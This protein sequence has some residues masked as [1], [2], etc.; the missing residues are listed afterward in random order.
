MSSHLSPILRF[1]PFYRRLQKENDRQRAEIARLRADQADWTRFFPPGHFYSPLSSREEIAE[2]FTRGGFGP[3]FADID[4][5]EAEQLARLERFA[6]WYPE[7]PFSENPA[8]GARFHLDNPSYGHFDAI[9]LYGM[10]R[11]ARPRRIV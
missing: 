6:A 1:L 3:P 2:A 10:L 4:L 8:S 9:M 7:Q 11:E 5:N